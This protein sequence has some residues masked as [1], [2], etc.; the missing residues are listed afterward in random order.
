[1][2]DKLSDHKRKAVRTE[3]DANASIERLTGTSDLIRL[4][5]ADLRRIGE[6]LNS[7]PAALE[8][9]GTAAVHIYRSPMLGHV[10][11]LTQTPLG[12]ASETTADE[13]IKAL[14][15]DA[16]VAYDRK[17]RTRRSGL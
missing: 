10:E 15:S 9:L 11:F 4:A 3:F 7:H 13:A 1:M 12:F 16:M 8:Y 2:T 6:R 5:A 17:R 14:K